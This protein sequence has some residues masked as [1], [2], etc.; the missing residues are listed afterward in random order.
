M[1]QEGD[2]TVKE[3]R[4]VGGKYFFTNA[5]MT[6]VVLNL[7]SSWLSVT[8]RHILS[9]SYQTINVG[10]WNNVSITKINKNKCNLFTT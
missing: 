6:I 10:L 1:I 7:H 2:L 8:I 5:N 9:E 3:R 4:I